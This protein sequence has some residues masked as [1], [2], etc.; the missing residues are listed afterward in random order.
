[1]TLAT[2]LTQSIARFAADTPID[3]L[4]V[5]ARAVMQLSLID[6]SACAV[7]GRDEPVSQ[8][9][10]DMV[11][12]EGGAA[13]ATV[14]GGVVGC[15]KVPARAAAL[16]NGTISHALDYDDTHFAHIGHPSVAVVPAALAVA[17]REGAD[18]AAFQAACLIGVEVATRIGIWL[19]RDHY[20]GGFH[21]TGTS[22]AFGAAMAAARLMGLTAAQCEMVLGLVATRASGLK[23]QF[24]TMGKPYNAGL[25]ASNGVEAADLVARGFAANP[26]ALEGALGFG[27]T[28]MGQADDLALADLGRV[29]LFQ[30]VSHKFHACCHGLHAALEALADLKPLPPEQVTAVEVTAHPRWQTVCHQL[31]PMTG[32]GAKFSYRTVIAMSLLGYDTARLDSYSDATCADPAIQALRDRVHVRFDPDVS[33]TAS[34]LRVQAR[35]GM[36]EAAHDLIAPVDLQ[37]RKAKVLAKARGL[38]G[39]RVALQVQEAVEQGASPQ[40]LAARLAACAD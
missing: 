35:S 30:D 38:L 24:G 7:A 13:Q 31:S 29:W 5:A 9:L 33:E 1:M 40:A 22:G 28:H 15:G 36:F 27:A 2:S 12:E 37:A 8:I 23:A 10:R 19:G 11:G 3:A 6:W 14:I 16:A 4:P 21:Q 26:K 32:L 20:Q 25:A 34:R 39:D 17:E 18:G